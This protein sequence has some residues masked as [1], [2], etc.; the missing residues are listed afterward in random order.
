MVIRKN[1]SYI[2]EKCR[3]QHLPMVP[4]FASAFK[5]RG[6][7]G[8]GI[9]EVEEPYEIVRSPVTWHLAL[10]TYEGQAEWKCNGKS[11]IMKPNEIWI[12]PAR[13]THSYK[14]IGN[15]KMISAALFELNAFA[16]LEG[17]PTQKNTFMDCKILANA[18]DAYLFE[19][20]IANDENTGPAESLVRYIS[21]VILRELQPEES[22][23]SNRT[24]FQINRL[25]E[26]VNATPGADWRICD[27]AQ[28]MYVSTRQFQ[29]MMRK[30]YGLTAEQMLIRIRME[31]AKELLT[32]SNLTMSLVAERVGYQS[33]YSFSKA[34][35]RSFDIS[36]GAY[37]KKFRRE[38]N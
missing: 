4:S 21:S 1:F 22:Y 27:L 38:N 15:W 36:P 3:D 29:R 32:A 20:D 16:H 12:A 10:F 23:D 14:A 2:P 19:A 13:L 6:I 24:H 8:V 30:H 18:V 37:A 35:K 33:E 9:H 28:R 17:H 5:D 26:E 7:R 31:Y 25:W 11:G 34:F